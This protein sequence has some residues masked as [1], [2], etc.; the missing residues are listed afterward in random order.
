MSKYHTV[1]LDDEF[2]VRDLTMPPFKKKVRIAPIELKWKILEKLYLKD[3]TPFLNYINNRIHFFVDKEF[4]HK[5]DQDIINHL[6][7]NVHNLKNDIIIDCP[8]NVHNL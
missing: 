6:N 3:N 8:T 5:E 1:R 2:T 4:I 7:D